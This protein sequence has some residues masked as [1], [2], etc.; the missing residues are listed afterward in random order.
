[1]ETRI[2]IAFVTFAKPRA[3]QQEIDKIRRRRIPARSTTTNF[4]AV[5]WLTGRAFP[6]CDGQPLNGWRHHP[7]RLTASGLSEVDLRTISRRHNDSG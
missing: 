6:Q 5:V 3:S 4:L 2:S 1:M 7:Q